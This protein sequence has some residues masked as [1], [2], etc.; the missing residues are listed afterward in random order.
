[1]T[2]SLIFL[3]R[4]VFRAC[5]GSSFQ[6]A[7]GGRIRLEN[8]GPPLDQTAQ[9]VAMAEDFVVGRDDDLDV[10]DVGVG[11]ENRLGAQRDVIVRR[12]PALF[13]AVFRR[14][15]GAEAEHARENVGKQ[16][17]SGDRAVAADRMEADAERALRKQVWIGL[18]FKR[19]PLCFRVSG[20]ESRLKRGHMRRR[21]L[22]KELRAKIDER[23]VAGLHVLER[24]DQVAWL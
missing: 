14:G 13:R 16:F 15:L 11:D 8:E 19:H 2:K 3:S 18:G 4:I 20:S 17:A 21:V 12:R 9:G 10:L 6:T 7:R 5:S 22:G 23:V 24:R 1:M